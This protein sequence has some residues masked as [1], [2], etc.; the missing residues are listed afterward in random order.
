MYRIALWL[1]LSFGAIQ[2]KAAV[3]QV[4]SSTTDIGEVSRRIATDQPTFDFELHSEQYMDRGQATFRDGASASNTSFMFRSAG[5]LKR[6]V[7]FKWDVESEYSAAENYN[8]LRP[9]ELYGKV[10]GLSFGRRKMTYSNWEDQW[11]QSLFEPRF[12]DDKLHNS[13]GGLVDVF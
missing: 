5:L 6:T 3:P 2:A 13:K 8:Y 4:N 1:G 7:Q 12:M 11:G 10:G 9:R